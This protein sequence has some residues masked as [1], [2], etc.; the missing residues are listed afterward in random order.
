MERSKT[1]ILCYEKI[2]NRLR[3][4]HSKLTGNK[5]H[6]DEMIAIWI[7]DE[8]QSGKYKASTLR[9]YKAAMVYML[10]NKNEDANR[11]LDILNEVTIPNRVEGKTP[12]KRTSA[13]KLK[14]ISERDLG[15]FVD[16]WL[17]ASKSKWAALLRLW[18]NA[19]L[20]TGLRPSEWESAR[21]GPN[22]QELIIR[23]AKATNGR[24]HGPERTLQLTGLKPEERRD[25]ICLV[26]ELAKG[27]A[28]KEGFEKLLKSLGNA[29]YRESRKCW[30]KWKR[31]LSLYTTRHQFSANMKAS[32][33]GRRELA[34]V[35]GHATDKTASIHYAKRRKGKKL[36]N[37]VTPRAEE[38]ERVVPK[39]VGYTPAQEPTSVDYEGDS[40]S[41]SKANKPR[42]FFR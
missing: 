28:S 42:M 21:L 31:H 11:A 16:V 20:S 3:D 8:A 14:H 7:W 19:S 41:V 25:I 2:V 12:P 38:I 18:L 24:A 5:G 29:L 35:M 33:I 39:Y 34:A 13:K 1:T 9:Q 17:P 26:R 10:E 6:L 23:N 37:Y 36:E 40:S 15:Y 32:G 27:Y 22:N 30:P 4:Q